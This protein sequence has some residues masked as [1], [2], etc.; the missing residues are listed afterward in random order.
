MFISLI[1]IFRFGLDVF[2]N[3]FFIVLFI[4]VVLCILL[5]LFLKLFFFIYFFV[6][7]YV[8]L[9]LVM[10]IVSIKLLFSLLINSFNIL[11][12]LN[13]SL[14]RIGVMMVIREGIIIFCCVFF[15]EIVI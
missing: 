7:F 1:R 10:K 4:I 8:L 12:I 2:L 6:L 11:G 9:V 15:V 5:F 13:I 3:G 14:V